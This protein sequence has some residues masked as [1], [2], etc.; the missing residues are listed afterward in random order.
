MKKF[1]S[2]V[3]TFLVMFFISAAT[4][5]SLTMLSSSNSPINTFAGD[6]GGFG[7]IFSG[8][9]AA[10]DEDKQFNINGDIDLEVNGKAVSLLVYVDADIENLDDLRFEGHINFKGENAGDYISFSYLNDTIYLST[11]NVAVKAEAATI[12]DLS[13]VIGG[14]VATTGEVEADEGE[15]QSFVDTLMPLLMDA[16]GNMEQTELENGD[17]R[18]T[19]TLEGY[20]EGILILDE[21]DRPKRVQLITEDISGIKLRARLF[22]DFNSSIVITSPELK[23]NSQDYLS[24]G[25]LTNIIENTVALRDI[26][27]NASLVF[28]GKDV[29]LNAIANISSGNYS[30]GLDGLGLVTYYNSD[31]YVSHDDINLM[32]TGNL[33]KKGA[34]SVKDIIKQKTSEETGEA[35]ELLNKIAETIKKVNPVELLNTLRTLQLVDGGLSLEL[36]GGL[37]GLEGHISLGV[38]F[39]EDTLNNLRLSGELEGHTFSGNVNIAKT[40]KTVSVDAEKYFDVEKI[41]N[42]NK[43]FFTSGALDA[44]INLL[45]SGDHEFALNSGVKIAK[46]YIEFGGSV[47]LG[48]SYALNLVVN[49]N[50]AYLNLNDIAVMG[51][52]DEIK[53]L[54][55][56]LG[57]NMDAGLDTAKL[58]DT[59]TEKFNIE[60]KDIKQL[61]SS[62]KTLTVG[63]QGV[64]IEFDGD[65]FNLGQVSLTISL[66]EEKI[67]QVSLGFSLDGNRISLDLTVNA[68]EITYT[69][70]DANKYLD[71]L[72][73]AENV[74]ALKDLT[75]GE[76]EAMLDGTIY[77]KQIEA[78]VKLDVDLDAKQYFLALAL[79]GD[80]DL[81]LDLRYIDGEIYLRIDGSYVKISYEKLMDL[82]PDDILTENKLSELVDREELKSRLSELDIDYGQI[83]QNAVVS[84]NEIKLALPGAIIGQNQDIVVNLALA[85]GNLSEIEIMNL[86][87]G[88]IAQVNLK[89]RLKI[90]QFDLGNF[91]RNDY[92]DL[93]SLGSVATGLFDAKNLTASLNMTLN[94]LDGSKYL[95]AS[96]DIHKQTVKEGL[97]GLANLSATM[98]DETISLFTQLQD[99][100]IYA[101]FNGLNVML[102]SSKIEDLYTKVMDLL[103]KDAQPYAEYLSRFVM[104]L[105]GANISDVLGGLN[106]NLS[107]VTSSANMPKFELNIDNIYNILKNIQINKQRIWTNLGG[108]LF[109][110]DGRIAIDLE[111]ENGL[112]A[113][114]GINNLAVKDKK[115][116]LKLNLNYA[117]P[118][119]VRLTKAETDKYINLYSLSN[120][121]ESVL[122]TLKNGSMSGN[123]L[124]D[125]NYGGE[126]NTLK[127]TYGIRLV[128]TTQ[129]P[130]SIK[131]YKLEGYLTGEFDGTTID[132]RYSNRTFYLDIMGLD[133]YAEFDS[134]NDIIAF[135][136][137]EFNANIN[138]DATKIDKFIDSLDSTTT[139]VDKKPFS[140]T[141]HSLATLDLDFVD[142][143]DFGENSLETYLSG[144]ARLFVAYNGKITQ[145][146]LNYKT[147]RAELNCT[148][149]ENFDLSGLNKQNYQ[150]YTILTDTYYA[151][152]NTLDALQ[153]NVVATATTHENGEISESA[154]VNFALDTFLRTNENNVQKRIANK[155]RGD[156]TISQKSGDSH[157]IHFGYMDSDQHL[158]FDYDSMKLSMDQ[159]A[160]R[161]LLAVVLSLLDVDP[162]T[163]SFL[164]EA[165]KDLDLNKDNLQGLAPNVDFGNPLA[166]IG[167]LKGITYEN[168]TLKIVVAASKINDKFKDDIT[169]SLTTN[170]TNVESIG[171]TNLYLGK[172]TKSIDFMLNF[173]GLGLRNNH[174]SSGVE[175]YTETKKVGE[176]NEIAD[177]ENT[178]SY[179]DITDS[180]NLV[181]AIVNTTSFKG[182][183][184]NGDIQLGIIGI[185]ATT[186]NADIKVALDDDGNPTIAAVITGYPLVGGVTAKNTNGAGFLGKWERN[187][188]IDVYYRDGYIYLRTFDNGWGAYGSLERMTKI[189]L[190]VFLDNLGGADGYVNWLLGFSDNIQNQIDAAIEKSRNSTDKTD[191]SKVLEAYSYDGT[192]HNIQ[193]NLGELVHNAD[194]GSLSVGLSTYKTKLGDDTEDHDYLYSML[195][196]LVLVNI[197]DLKTSNDN[198]L[199][200]DGSGKEVVIDT[201]LMDNYKWPTDGEYSSTGG[202]DFEQ[203]NKKY[204]TITL[205]NDGGEGETSLRG[206]VGAKLELPTPQKEVRIGNELVTYE[207]VGYYYQDGTKF[208]G[209]GFPRED[210]TLVAHWK[211][212]LRRTYHTVT[213]QFNDGREDYVF[214]V[215]EGEQIVLQNLVRDPEDHKDEKYCI[216]FIFE[217][218]YQGDVRFRGGVMLDQDIVLQARWKPSTKNYYDIT[219]VSE[220]GQAPETLRKLEGTLINEIMLE[221]VNAYDGDLPVTYKFLGWFDEE[222]NK[223][224]DFTLQRDITL[225]ARWQEIV[226]EQYTFTIVDG[227]KEVYSGRVYEGMAIIMD[228]ELSVS[229]ARYT[230]IRPNTQLFE[231]QAFT[232]RYS[233]E[234]ELLSGENAGKYKLGVMPSADFTLYVRNLYTVNYQDKYGTAYS[235]Q[236]YYQG[237][238]IKPLGGFVKDTVD[239]GEKVTAYTYTG[240]AGLPSEN[241]MPNSDIT[242]NVNWQE[243]IKYWTNVNFTVEYGSHGAHIDA[244]QVYFKGELVASGKRTFTQRLLEGTEVVQ[245]VDGVEIVW[246]YKSLFSKYVTVHMTGFEINMNIWGSGDK[247][248]SFTVKADSNKEMDVHVTVD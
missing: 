49:G 230:L 182:F 129:N 125:F 223:L 96:A 81:G 238:T 162:S 172:A 143:V 66:E 94:N 173:A 194:I 25:R 30:L 222:G 4:T 248:Q 180:P 188:E 115:L 200:L 84:A 20:G 93:E 215:L 31:L 214:E 54:L 149:Y 204:V 116:S 150:P 105:N 57:V 62:I 2:Y 12:G 10:F 108:E 137:N 174:T 114:L 198:P 126:V 151:I 100:S 74:Y 165:S 176:V 45:V 120:A 71:V 87:I 91:Y 213:I 154:V 35:A 40:E 175:E 234:P 70:V 121:F 232:A 196:N 157:L 92:L 75:V 34:A 106:V 130:Q 56:R 203:G 226:P 152:R 164:Q 76:I 127:L 11:K 64:T 132:I 18:V 166:L 122:N 247:V 228:N 23:E 73:L 128:K 72:A 199:H 141:F 135:I 117:Q 39:E 6:E 159:S 233:F 85:G 38:D 191:V 124:F 77:G 67:K 33:L 218:Y 160:F 26:E 225:T 90:G 14:L 241:I 47:A 133:I 209:D 243:D 184:I 216:F 138:F 145:V 208:N 102:S 37:F 205:D 201:S 22:A 153:F 193:I 17:K 46:N 3:M 217:G 103:G 146:V 83:I 227:G 65:M 21:D 97:L 123:I 28:D 178:D 179:I 186:I 168:G 183:H 131:D 142:H 206:M 7:N 240:L 239:D 220:Y 140:E 207:F 68:N 229:G 139:N 118:E 86:V 210:V 88:E 80:Y 242:I 236:T 147:Y 197:L 246:S 36:D 171:L 82:L 177:I 202:R 211:E 69:T 136:N 99:G 235:G 27:A 107:A 98:N 144:D 134:L 63:D 95:S 244:L 224:T 113:S 163:I 190:Q 104:L 212:S 60:N 221:N 169:V 58:K 101:S 170:K 158:Y 5:V 111:L 42:I 119:I 44:T 167:L 8:I 24:L 109:G 13:K 61:L 51:N 189:S 16:L 192:F 43:D 245:G 237:E 231:D 112:P 78:S 148:S 156:V 55:S 41:I 185:D 32:L 1:L 53:D 187:R 19:L 15:S 50:Y 181:K 29:D 48:N 219:F 110:L 79:N 89:A 52:L 59:L 9:L 161:E 195:M 155:F